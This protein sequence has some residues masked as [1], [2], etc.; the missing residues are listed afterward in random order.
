MSFICLGCSFKFPP[1]SA[2]Q[3]L[4]LVSFPVHQCALHCIAQM[5]TMMMSCSGGGLH[6][7]TWMGRAKCVVQMPHSNRLRLMSNQC[8]PAPPHCTSCADH[9]CLRKA[10]ASLALTAWPDPHEV[11]CARAHVFPASA[12]I[13]VHHTASCHTKNDDDNITHQS[14]GILF[15]HLE[16][17]VSTALT[18][19]QPR[20][21]STCR[22]VPQ[23]SLAQIP[24]QLFDIIQTHQFFLFLFK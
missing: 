1:G 16:L 7:Q 22:I 17:T 9:L 6:L 21:E 18:P 20:L 24:E 5:M 23:C 8:Q 11:P 10:R 12:F 3:G 4:C 13:D 15:G 2:H 19:P 14:W